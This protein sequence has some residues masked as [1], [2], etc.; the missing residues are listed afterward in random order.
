MERGSWLRKYAI[1]WVGQKLSWIGSKAGGFALVWWLTQKTGSA[2]VLATATMALILPTV[3]LGPIAGAYVDRWNRRLT[4][5]ISDSFIALVSLFL[6][7]LFW[8]GQMEI[9]HI[10]LVIVARS[11]GNAFHEPAMGASTA[12]LVPK[13]HLPRIAGLNQ[14]AKGAMSV[15]GPV[16]GALLISILPLHG[17]M[18]ID[19]A[20]AAFAIIP[21]F[22]LSIPQPTD[23]SAREMKLFASLR[24]GL[25]FVLKHR[26]LLT[27]LGIASLANCLLNPAFVLLPL[28]VT[29][30]FGGGALHLGW[31][32]SGWGI[33]LIVG[34]L[35][36]SVWGGFRQRVFT[37][38]ISGVLQ[39]AAVVSLGLVPAGLFPIALVALSAHGLFNAFHNGSYSALLQSIV[40][41]HMQGRV[42]TLMESVVQSIYPISLAIVGPVV[43]VI[44]LRT[45]YVAGGLVLVCLQIV[46]LLAPSI[47][48]LEA[49]M[50]KDP[51]QVP[52]AVAAD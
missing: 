6:A 20:T 25:G 13:E 41:K 39:A 10:Y 15:A 31:L 5:I 30:H 43:A 28:L 38:Y 12:M 51:E 7:Y 2:Q 34:G 44:G 4:I 37:L 47:R 32:Q 8:S 27:I 3:L 22:F 29:Q 24:V 42:F 45:W 14:A 21:L 9:W 46:A 18:L 19:V 17:V 40:P 23:R 35:A 1:I 48:N 33:G 16:L 50:S 52:E 36:L 26:G 49:N 11:I